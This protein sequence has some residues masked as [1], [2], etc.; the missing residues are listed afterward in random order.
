MQLFGWCVI[1][2]SMYTVIL[3]HWYSNNGNWNSNIDFEYGSLHKFI[4][5]ICDELS[6][7]CHLS[8]A[9]T[10]K[11]QECDDP[12]VHC[13][14]TL[15]KHRVCLAVCQCL[16]VYKGFVIDFLKIWVLYLIHQLSWEA[17]NIHVWFKLNTYVSH[18]HMIIT[19][20]TGASVIGT[21]YARHKSFLW[22]CCGQ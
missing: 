15:Q 1:L 7:N 14:L 10:L 19:S 20:K 6:W 5:I 2:W 12:F 9:Q 18:S 22:K 16:S 11:G 13:T 17:I 21:K 3:Y 4:N 8:L